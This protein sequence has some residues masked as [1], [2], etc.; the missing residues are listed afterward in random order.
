MVCI[1]ANSLRCLS[2]VQSSWHRF[3][4]SLAAS[5]CNGRP[6]PDTVRAWSSL[7]GGSKSPS[8][9]TDVK[10]TQRLGHVLAQKKIEKNNDQNGAGA[11]VHNKLPCVPDPQRGCIKNTQ[12]LIETLARV[13]VCSPVNIV[14]SATKIDFPFGNSAHPGI[15]AEKSSNQQ[16]HLQ[17]SGATSP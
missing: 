4:P 11:D 5:K 17:P 10:P 7:R 12:A 2:S 1:S 8:S 13:A 15:F 3:T 16:R 9:L 14:A 6:R